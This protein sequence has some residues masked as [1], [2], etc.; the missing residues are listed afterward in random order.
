MVL[1]FFPFSC[2]FIFSFFLRFILSPFNQ[3]SLP[4]IPSSHHFTVLTFKIFFCFIHL[5]FPFVPLAFPPSLFHSFLSFG[6][7]NLASSRPLVALPFT[8]FLSILTL[9]YP[10]TLSAYAPLLPS[11][12]SPFHSFLPI[13]SLSCIFLPTA[14]ISFLLHCRFILSKFF[15]CQ[16]PQSLLTLRPALLFFV[17]P[18]VSL[19]S[20]FP[21]AGI[22]SSLHT[23]ARLSHAHLLTLFSISTLSSVDMRRL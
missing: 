23:P 19:R 7:Y 22:S 18:S 6:S 20:S 14:G 10:P 2:Y 21:P 9:F 1:Y 8:L 15:F 16:L 13:C 3:L 12:L 5:L 4:A 17:S 11:P